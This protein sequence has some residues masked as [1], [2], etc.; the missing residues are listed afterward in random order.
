M[1]RIRSIW[2]VV[3]PAAV[4]LVGAWQRRWMADD[5]FIHLRVVEQILHGHGPVFNAGERVEASTSPLWVLV[6]AV[7][8]APRVIGPEKAAV[9]LALLS[10]IAGLLLAAWGAGRLW[11]NNDQD[12]KAWFLPLGAVIL[13]VLP[14][15]WDFATSGLE[16]GFG[17]L[18]LGG[19]FALLAR[20]AT[21]DARCPALRAVALTAGLGPLIRPEFAL[22]TA[23]FL[24]AAIIL[25]AEA[26]D[27]P[28][29]FRLV[30]LVSGLALPAAY[31]IF[32]MGYYGALVPNTAFAKEASRAWWSQG[33]RYLGDFVG[34]YWIWLPMLMVAVLVALSARHAWPAP[35][36]RLVV[37]A[38]PV[39][40]GVA[41]VL[42]ITRVGGDFMH[43]R[44]LL[45]GLF[46]VVMPV[47]VCR[48]RTAPQWLAAATVVAWAVVCG[49]QLRV[50]YVMTAD[51]LTDERAFYTVGTKRSNPITAPDFVRHPFHEDA[52]EAKR[53]RRDGQRLVVWRPD[54]RAYGFATAPLRP[55][56]PFPVAFSSDYVGVM[57]FVSGPD[58]YVA[59]RMGLGDTLAARVEITS[60]GRP[61]H[62][63]QL[64]IA[65]V[66]GR[67]AD[68]AAAPPADVP[69][70]AVDA[71]RAAL[72]CGQL[73]DLRAATTG[74]LSLGRFVRNLGV[75]LRLQSF[76]VD[77]D[78]VIAEREI[79][80][81]SVRNGAP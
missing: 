65:W 67:L 50:P 66:L 40:G 47:M 35:R 13:A 53:L 60:R 34:T 63:K 41:H 6:L 9:G 2:L 54:Y 52:A 70:E 74:R 51:G 8:S 38:A 80:R 22:F 72:Q 11:R 25:G 18:W 39:V 46:A 3:V 55:D 43:G 69:R 17:F 10:T 36:H 57:G 59:D 16:T 76:R 81:R 75:A 56:F 23:V 33:F 12:R 26:T 30:L 24:G 71:A 15:M 21:S 64:P 48:I 5:A 7:V 68:P 61:G 49:A 45:P 79:C 14:P 77:R 1:R 28:R 62:E 4:L 32:R 29:R 19:C 73:A 78:P 42:Y 27:R 58:I 37:L 31:Q 20:L 44:L